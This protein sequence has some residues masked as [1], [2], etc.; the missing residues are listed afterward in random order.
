[1]NFSAPDLGG[2]IGGLG[3]S[4]GGALGG[5]MDGFNGLL[6]GTLGAAGTGLLAAL[7]LIVAALLILWLATR[8]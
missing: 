6:H 5:L 4:L 2:M 3:S 1:M 8:R 7:G